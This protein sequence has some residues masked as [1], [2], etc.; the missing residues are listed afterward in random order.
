MIIVVLI[1]PNPDP[2]VYGWFKGIV[3][4][5]TEKSAFW[6]L[7]NNIII[8]ITDMYLSLSH[9]YLCQEIWWIAQ[10]YDELINECGLI[11]SN[12]RRSAS[13]CRV[14]CCFCN[15]FE[16]LNE[17]N[18]LI[19][20]QQRRNGEKETIKVLHLF[21]ACSSITWD[22]HSAIFQFP[23]WNPSMHKFTT[24]FMESN[25]KNS[26]S[27]YAAQI[28]SWLQNIDYN[29]EILQIVKMDAI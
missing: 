10:Y 29:I 2:N 19:S 25:V 4:C 8:V 21:G 15:Q 7:L 17:G 18:S 14:P 11:W 28:C 20:K 27:L 1:V 13:M 16:R 12:G 23:I 24:A 5:L 9:Y 22:I 26:F 6:W 3:G